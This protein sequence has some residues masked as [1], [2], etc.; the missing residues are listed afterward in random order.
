MSVAESDETQVEP[1]H[2]DLYGGAPIKVGQEWANAL[3][4]G[5]GAALSVVGGIYLFKTAV[6]I[7]SGLAIACVAYMLSV[8]GTFLFSTLSHLIHRQ[9]AL[10]TLRAWDQ[11]MIYTMISGTYTPIA[12]VFAPES[13]RGP[14]LIAI[15]VAAIA[16][17]AAKVAVRH[18][19]NSIGTWSYILLGWLPAIPLVGNVPSPLAWSM[20]V[21]GIVY[22]AGVLF[23]INDSKV[24]YFHAV[25]HLFVMFAAACHF[26]GI[27]YYVVLGR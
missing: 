7:E 11:A 21:G 20:T 14:L 18:R 5:I 12:Y 22:S 4:H 27:F 16:G 13:V 1:T 25:W 24:R 23:L 2:D 3:T 26:G 10:N 15:W 9:P 6:S 8:F 19:I 17:F